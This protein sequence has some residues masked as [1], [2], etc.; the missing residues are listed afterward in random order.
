VLVLRH[1][2]ASFPYTVKKSRA[3][4]R[5][6][7]A[8]FIFSHLPTCGLAKPGTHKLWVSSLVLLS[9]IVLV[10]FRKQRKRKDSARRI[11]RKRF[12]DRVEEWRILAVRAVHFVV[13]PRSTCAPVSCSVTLRR[14]GQTSM[15]ELP[16]SDPDGDHQGED[17]S[18]AE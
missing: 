15:H 2:E 7:A 16:M 8:S 4:S 5:R 14:C 1:T 13:T 12:V 3:C 17:L 6:R 10:L 11:A 18:T 9:P